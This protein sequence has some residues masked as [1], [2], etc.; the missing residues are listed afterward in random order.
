MKRRNIICLVVDRLRAAALGAYGAASCDTPALDRLASEAVLFDAA[1]ADSPQLETIYRGLWQGLSALAPEETSAQLP[2]LPMV[3]STVGYNVT[4][5]T[6]ETRVAEHPLASDFDETIRLALPEVPEVVRHWEETQLARFFAAAVEQIEALSARDEPFALW[7]HAS[8]MES[9]WDA[10][11]EFR[12]SLAD[13]EDPL[14]PSG[15]KVP[16]RLLPEDF[17]PDE[18]LGA[19]QAYAGQ[20]MVFD[21]CTEALLEYVQSASRTEETLFVLCGARGFPLGEHRRIGAAD[22][23]LYSELLHVPCLLRFPDRQGMLDRIGA[24]TQLADLPV[25]LLDWLQ[26]PLPPQWP[27]GC[28]STLPLIAGTAERLRDALLFAGPNGERGLRTPAWYLRT[29]GAA[30]EDQRELYAKPDDRWEANEVSRR[31]TDLAD[32]LAAAATQL[33]AAMLSNPPTTPPPLAPAL[34]DAEF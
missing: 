29:W 1:F 15:A 30:A 26:I 4:L 23:A 18:L 19:A 8:G 6:D 14:P 16:D 24:L 5:L 32:E 2:T 22:E 10:P 13:E 11:L 20:M 17:D 33:E 7:L 12:N 25:T 28:L 9:T 27:S 21:R 3:L 34:I 31:L